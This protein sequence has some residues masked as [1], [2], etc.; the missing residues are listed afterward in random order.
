MKRRV[1]VT[2]VA[3]LFAVLSVMYVNG[4]MPFLDT[5]DME[6]ACVC[7]STAV[8][9]YALSLWVRCKDRFLAIIIS[10]VIVYILSIVLSVVMGQNAFALLYVLMTVAPTCGAVLVCTLVALFCSK[11]VV[12]GRGSE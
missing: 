9:V 3:V 4:D 2:I 11:L 5:I 1:I 8:S 7:V 6:I 12:R 10:D